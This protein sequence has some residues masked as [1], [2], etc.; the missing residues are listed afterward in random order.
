MLHAHKNRP[1]L[2]ALRNK[3]NQLFKIWIGLFVKDYL[4][5]VPVVPSGQDGTNGTNGTISPSV[6]IDLHVF[7]VP[8]IG[9]GYLN[10][11]LFLPNLSCLC[12]VDFNL[13]LHVHPFNSHYTQILKYTHANS[14]DFT[15]L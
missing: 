6:S 3:D 2:S 15:L 5:V 13:T 10:F 9:S 8:T 11:L 7:S 12:V 1:H 14:I 4:L